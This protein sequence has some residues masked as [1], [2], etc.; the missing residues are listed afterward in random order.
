MNAP[1]PGGKQ[2][3]GGIVRRLRDECR[4]RLAGSLATQMKFDGTIYADSGAGDTKGNS[5]SGRRL[6][7]YVLEIDSLENSRLESRA[8][9]TVSNEGKTLTVVNRPVNSTAVFTEVWDKQ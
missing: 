7:D 5:S 3:A 8:E 1:N 4:K 2:Q 9:L 6:S